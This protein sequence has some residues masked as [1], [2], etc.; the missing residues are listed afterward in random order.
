MQADPTQRDQVRVLRPATP[1]EAVALAK[2]TGAPYIAGGSGLQPVWERNGSW[3]RQ[4]VALN[5]CWPGFRGIEETGQGLRVGALT[6]LGELARHPLIHRYLPCLPE[7]MDQVAG[8]GVRHLGTVGGNLCAGGDLS[9]LFLALDAQ[10]HRLSDDDPQE[11]CEPLEDYS[12]GDGT[13]MTALSLPDSRQWRIGL[14]KLGY[15]ERF[16]PPRATVACVHDGQTLRRAVCGEGGPTRLRGG[17]KDQ[18]TELTAGGWQ[19]P[20]LRLA[21]Q[22]M[23]A[24][25]QED[26][27]RDH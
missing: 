20:A 6:T 11:Q 4:L 10:V 3:P 5:P 1:R 16:S 19:D 13:L 26:I 8:P 24:F 7:F 12:A 22:R 21:I 25:L 14:E 2:T 18:D 27:A 17:E 23:L 15:R 9:A